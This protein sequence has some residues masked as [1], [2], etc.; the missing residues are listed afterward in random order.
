[1][2]RFFLKETA[3]AVKNVRVPVAIGSVLGAVTKSYSEDQQKK[4]E[5]KVSNKAN[6]FHHDLTPS[7]RDMISRAALK[8]AIGGGVLG[9]SYGLCYVAAGVMGTA[10]GGPIGGKVAETVTAT[11]AIAALA[12]VTQRARGP[13]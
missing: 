12:A 1:M 7:E 9:A 13:R 8:G 5:I 3:M 6:G 10:L 11:A 4:L 2:F